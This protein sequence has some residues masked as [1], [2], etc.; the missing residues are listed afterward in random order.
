VILPRAVLAVVFD[1]DGLLC[2]TEV[3]FRD[4]L[5]DAARDLG[6]ELPLAVFHDMIGTPVARSNALLMQHFGPGFALPAYHAAVNVRATKALA[7]GA[8]LKPG[9]VE[10]LDHLDERALPR[11]IATSSGHASVRSHLGPSGVLPR[12]NAVVAR[13]DYVEG[14]PH[15][16]PFLTAA[17]RLS[18]APSSCLALEDSYNGVRAAHAAGMMTI[19]VPDLLEATAEME[20]LC[21]HV[22][23]SLHEVRI[24]LRAQP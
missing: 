11:A 19:M 18:V 1:M 12:F 2:D 5:M 24:L 22:A 17:G 16:E 4:V 14:K 13:G 6:F 8:A 21:V 3:I 15:P 7:H 10:L 20:A 9:V 23:A